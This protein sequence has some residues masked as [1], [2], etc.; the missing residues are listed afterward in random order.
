M[1]RVVDTEFIG[2]SY[3]NVNVGSF[4]DIYC[5]KVSNGFRKKE[6]FSSDNSIEVKV[7]EK[8]EVVINENQQKLPNDKSGK[9]IIPIAKRIIKECNSKVTLK[10]DDNEVRDQCDHREK[11][12]FSKYF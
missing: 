5:H 12:S 6:M 1:R 7:G 9:A 11:L 8:T 10:V 4:L 2:A 3:G